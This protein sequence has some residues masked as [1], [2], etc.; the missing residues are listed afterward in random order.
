VKNQ[1]YQA[2]GIVTDTPIQDIHYH[3]VR[4]NGQRENPANGKGQNELDT[5]GVCN[6]KLRIGL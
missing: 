3:S 6:R 1:G 2:W 4:E 5:I